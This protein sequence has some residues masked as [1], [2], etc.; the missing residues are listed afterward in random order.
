[1][2]RAPYVGLLLGAT[3]I[4]L[5]PIL[6]RWSEVGPLATAFGRLALAVPVLAL[7]FLVRPGAAPE[8]VTAANGVRPWGL[9]SLAGLFFAADLAVWHGSLLLTSVT[10]ATLL[11]NLGP[12]FMALVAWWWWRQS[13]SPRLV[14][15]LVLAFL[16]A[17]LLMA[18]RLGFVRAQGIGDL[19]GLA[20]AVFYAGYLLAIARL[21]VSQA[22]AWVMFGST[23][24]GALAMI[25]LVLVAGEAFW[26]H[27]VRGW[28]VLGALALVSHVAG[29]GLIAW[30]LAHLPTAAGAAG[31]LWQP[32]AAALLA[33][34]LLAEPLGP[35]QILG[36]GLVLAGIFLAR[37]APR[38]PQPNHK[39]SQ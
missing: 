25:P 29:Q 17:L 39:R 32:V 34:L 14:A 31:L 36:G 18:D 11:G 6:V 27:S 22:T 2:S 5:A 20:T 35:W 3:A 30:A 7:W 21:R 1:M 9:V 33:W 8:Q 23:L 16:G 19:L 13:P 12:L 26:P 38:Q 4:G 28:A 10:N 24:V 15:G 37:T